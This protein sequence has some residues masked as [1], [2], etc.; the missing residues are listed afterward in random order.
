MYNLFAYFDIDMVDQTTIHP[1]RICMLSICPVRKKPEESSEMISQIIFGEQVNV[2]EHKGSW[3][4]IQ[5]RMDMYEGWVDEKLLEPIDDPYDE[6]SADMYYCLDQSAPIIAG[7]DSRMITFGAILPEYDGMSFKLNGQKFTFQGA[8]AKAGDLILTE[9]Q[10]ERL[11]RKYLNAPY[12]WGGKTP[13]GADCSGFVQAIYRVLG[14]NLPRDAKDQAHEGIDVGFVHESMTG[15]LAFFTKATNRISHVGIVLD[16][17]KVIHASGQVRI[18]RLDHDGI[19]N[20]E[21]EK[22]THK[23]RIIKRVL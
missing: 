23:L 20:A 2:L 14:V 10:V 9:K 1:S 11:C 12:L 5:S 19:Y 4:Y 21:T 7:E 3:L 6:K 13:F 8:A 15:D 16:D 22:Y 18:D 17:D